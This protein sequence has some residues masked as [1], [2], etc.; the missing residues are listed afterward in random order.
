MRCVKKKF[1]ENAILPN[2]RLNL[3][4]NE[5]M[6]DVSMHGERREHNEMMV[7]SE[8]FF[9]F[10]EWGL[11]GSWLKLSTANGKSVEGAH[12]EAKNGNGEVV[13]FHPGLPG[14]GVVNFENTFVKSL[15]DNGYDVFVARHNGLRV[16][17][18]NKELFHN[19]TRTQREADI[20]DNPQSWFSEPEV[21]IRYFAQQNKTIS[22][23]SHSFSGISTAN[24]LIDLAKSD[25]NSGTLTH[26]KKWILAA[27]A[28]WNLGE[29]GVLDAAK[30]LHI[31][32][33]EGFYQSISTKYTKVPG[34]TTQLLEK[35]K[36]TLLKIQTEIGGSLPANTD[37]IGIYP[38]MDQRVSPEIGIHLLSTLQRGTIFRDHH[39]PSKGE[40]PHDLQHV[41]ADDLLRILKLPPSRTRHVFDVN[42]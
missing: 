24:S 25:Q 4:N 29:D 38:E 33:L 16:I 12:Y 1:L 23:V 22:L 32:D 6:R 39:A 35:T 27:A 2:D 15:L 37:I 21:T 19:N 3:I 42:K 26:V 11:K 40:D 7:E 41:Q 36:E 8:K 31:D 20:S 13:V 9:D 10:E 30:G 34:A 5:D 18:D 14:D 28:V 17:D